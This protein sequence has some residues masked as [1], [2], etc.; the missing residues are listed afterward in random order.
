[1][2]G[3][4][5]QRLTDMAGDNPPK[6]WTM[7][8]AR[9]ALE[10]AMQHNQD[11]MNRLASQGHQIDGAVMLKMRLDFVT[12]FLLQQAGPEVQFN[13]AMNWEQRLADVLEH[14]EQAA[15]RN[16]LSLPPG[17]QMPGQMSVDDVLGG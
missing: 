6:V 12:E 14:A 15:R 13:F 8:E 9:Q 7:E 3:Q 5:G 1:M 11:T 17:V 2:S 4:D 10:A 16:T